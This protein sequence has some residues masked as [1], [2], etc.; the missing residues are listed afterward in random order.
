MGC[1]DANTIAAFVGGRAG[2]EINRLVDEHIDVCEECHRC[3]A[4][5]ARATLPENATQPTREPRSSA[6][7]HDWLDGRFESLRAVAKGGM[8]MVHQARDHSTGDVVA[9]KFMVGRGG[10]HA[11][12]FAREASVLASLSH[13]SIVRYVA[14]GASVDGDPFLAMEWIE[15]VSL[16][17]RLSEGPLTIAETVDL[18]I[19]LCDALRAAHEAGVVHRDL[20]PSNIVLV[21]GDPSKP[22]IIDFG[23]A[24]G[25]SS[26]NPLTGPGMSLGTPAYMAPEQARDAALVD[27]RADL[28]SLGCL[29]YRALAGAHPFEARDGFGMVARVLLDPPSPLERY[30][31]GV[32][33]LLRSLLGQLLEKDAS[34]R[35]RDVVE[36]RLALERVP[37]GTSESGDAS[38]GP[39]SDAPVG[40]LSG[41]QR[42]VLCVLLLHAERGLR[43]ADREKVEALVESFGGRLDVLRG[44]KI[45]ITSS[46]MA[47]PQDQAARAARL[48][49]ALR[50]SIARASMSLVLGSLTLSAATLWG[51]VIDRGV[52]QLAASRPE[53][54]RVDATT[55]ALLAHRFLLASS[56]DGVL[57]VGERDSFE[58]PKLLA[59]RETPTEGRDPE[60]ALLTAA[61]EQAFAEREARLL[62]IV[63]PPGIGKSRLCQELVRRLSSFEP[64]PAVLVGAA[65]PAET[66]ASYSLLA[67]MVR[68]ARP[69]ALSSLPHSPSYEQLQ[70]A[71]ESFVRSECEQRPLVLVLEDVQ[72]ADVTSLRIV[73]AIIRHAA[74]LPLVVVALTRTGTG[75]P[76]ERTLVHQRAAAQVHLAPLSRSAASRVVRFVLGA[77][78]SS[79]AIAEIVQRAEGNPFFL[80]E[81]VRARLLG[82]GAIP[83]TVIGAL[84]A[85]IDGAG[86]AGR[87]VLAVG[88]IFGLSFWSGGVQ[89]VLDQ[90]GYDVLDAVNDLVAS[91]ML[92]ERGQSRI[93]MSRELKFA[94]ELVREAAL[95]TIAKEDLA[96]LHLSAAAWLESVLYEDAC[97]IADHWHRGGDNARARA[98]YLT[99]ARQALGLGEMGSVHAM[100][101]KALA[102]GPS[103]AERADLLLALAEAQIYGDQTAALAQAE[104]A[105]ALSEAGSAPFFE[106]IGLAASAAGGLGRRDHVGVLADRLIAAWPDGRFDPAAALAAIRLALNLYYH[107]DRARY[108]AVMALLA[109]VSG[110]ISDDAI[111]ARYQW[112]RALG[113]VSESPCEYL[114]CMERAAGAFDRC[115]HVRNALNARVSAAFAL[116]MLG[117]HTRA[118]DELEALVPI[119]DRLDQ[120]HL[121]A[122][123]R[124]NLGLAL[125][126]LG[127]F[128]RAFAFES[129]ALKTFEALSES[130]MIGTTQAYLARIERGRGAPL[131]AREHLLMG[132]GSVGPHYPWLPLLYAELSAAELALGDVRAA[133]RAARDGLRALRRGGEGMQ[134][135]LGVLSQAC[136]AASVAR[137][138]NI[139]RWVA[140]LSARRL[141]L[142]AG[143]IDDPGLR[144]SYLAIPE[145]QRLLALS[146]GSATAPPA[147]P[148]TN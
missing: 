66:V 142:R 94:S 28:F 34:A 36:V 26:E 136:A 27:A 115:G 44:G 43:R 61:C 55:G 62:N 132:L 137:R 67:D 51:P 22:K 127:D 112:V 57:L 3:V 10:I 37:T 114:R 119:A 124:H 7:A 33:P 53:E 130:R 6:R 74:D 98:A 8:G 138:P 109:A 106:A 86:E 125:L 11:E 148:A 25:E 134:D 122:S 102:L 144:A 116:I 30:R 50:R 71:W 95:A 117:A 39:P 12:R 129:Q 77:D 120:R 40:L 90:E 133:L 56:E 82:G 85:R 59:G 41:V 16:K 107:A 9:L 81:I 45:V 140:I 108:V 69:S 146:T 80:E 58:A 139:A 42:R 135:D 79:Q 118:R 38:S 47:T 23:V 20:K 111:V 21:G 87:R 73:D 83:E 113:R 60:I 89:S 17:D 100:V 123:A 101:A 68:R 31:R 75:A 29:L 49:L 14:H 15:G 143:R 46:A 84:Q 35:P 32:P 96:G 126:H 141:E 145:H 70:L 1:L 48:A 64:R 13:P 104:E 54:I 24:R 2:S 105:L 5:A 18:G 19:G 97:A 92:V 52:E 72:W 147:G 91:E 103:V 93:A 128:E 110:S 63:G 99:A 76:D 78:A 131:R 4:E 88:S 65:D 121:A